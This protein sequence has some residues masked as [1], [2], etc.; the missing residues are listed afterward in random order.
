MCARC[1]D[2][3]IVVSKCIKC[4]LCETSFH[5]ACISLKEDVYK[6]IVKNDNVFWFCEQCKQIVPKKLTEAVGKCG[7]KSY[8]SNCDLITQYT[9]EIDYLQRE[10]EL[11]NKLVAEMD[12]SNNLLKSRVI[13]LQEKVTKTLPDKG[14]SFLQTYSNVVKSNVNSESA[15][16][17]VKT[18]VNKAGINCDVVNMLKKSVNLA[19]TNVCVNGAKSIKN[20]AAIY[21]KDVENLNKL[22][23]AIS[24][25]FGDKFNV[26]EAQKLQ[27]RILVKNI[28]ISEDLSSADLIENIKMLNN[29]NDISSSELK[30]VIVLKKF[31]KS[32]LVLEVSPAVRKT[33][34]TN[35]YVWIG[36]KKCAVTDHIH[37]IQCLK[38][39]S[40]GHYAKNCKFEAT[41][42]KCSGNHDRENCNVDTFVC[43][44]CKMHNAKY[45]TSYSVDHMA[46]DK[47]CMVYKNKVFN[48]KSKINYD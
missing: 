11:L 30:I 32:D 35:G 43:T 34:I 22:K 27:P 42:S 9:K 45:K 44:N 1:A 17:L 3:F 39:F 15:V 18:K 36:W 16:L 31:N 20:G 14:T 26:D 25:K 19:E 2:N 33:L 23:E 4:N 5:P 6:V 21:C 46:N 38:C 10:K 8:K 28:Q 47:E 13:E 37:V 7:E 41:C 48:L 24:S 29:L 40:F 12:C